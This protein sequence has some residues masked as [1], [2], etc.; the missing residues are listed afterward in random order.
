MPD[1]NDRSPF[2]R[3]GGDTPGGAPKPRFAP[4]LIVPVLLVALLIFNS[5][6]SRAAQ[7]SISYSEFI[8]AVEQDQLD[9]NTSVKISDS[10]ISGALH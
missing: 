1:D 10:A 3:R 8:D 7:D 5:F 4:W 6:L 9:P 2:S